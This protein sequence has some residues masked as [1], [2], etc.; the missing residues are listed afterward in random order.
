MK[1]AYNKL[2]NLLNNRGLK[3]SLHILDNECPNV[4]NTF[5]REVNEKFQSVPPHI[6]HRNLAERAIRN[7]KEHFVARLASTHKDFPLHT[8]C[9]LLPHASI[10]LNLLRKLR[11]NPKLSGYAQ[12][13]GDFNY[14][15][16]PLSPPSTQIIVHK[17]PRL[18][19][20][21]VAHV[22]KRW[23]LGPSMEKYRC[24][25]IYITKKN[26]GALFRLC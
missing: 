26:R 7:F 13:H 1:T 5:M 22:V 17:K 16:N 18:R 4:I 23:H 20:T 9:R 2:H 3:P 24:H 11:T 21:W 10:T 19:G 14:N 25:N 6:H 12:L 15:V 8:W